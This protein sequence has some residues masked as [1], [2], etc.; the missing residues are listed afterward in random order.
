M[1]NIRS[2]QRPK[3]KVFFFWKYQYPAQGPTKPR[4]I[5]PNT[6]LW[7]C[8]FKVRTYILLCMNL[9]NSFQIKKH[10]LTVTIFDPDRIPPWH[11]PVDIAPQPEYKSSNFISGSLF[12]TLFKLFVGFEFTSN[13][14]FTSV[15]E[16][17]V[18]EVSL[19]VS[20]FSD[21]Q[22]C[23]KMRKIWKFEK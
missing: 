10:T 5:N 6:H 16:E 20:L 2:K 7:G 13:L 8:T 1:D 15:S 14:P 4:D 18:E 11:K 21:L 3:Y 22:I 19:P 23:N 17:I 12:S 9:L